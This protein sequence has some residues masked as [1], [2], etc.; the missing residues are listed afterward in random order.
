M[1][2]PSPDL[3]AAALPWLVGALA[4]GALWLWLQAEPVRHYERR[5]PGTDRVGAPPPP[6][7]A[8]NVF[9][10]GQSRT[11]PGQPADIAGSWP[12]FRGAARDG[13]AAANRPLNL[14]WGQTPPPEL[15]GVE[16]G[17]GYAAPAIEAGR[18]FLLDYDRQAQHD[19]MRCWSLEDGR[20]IW[21]YSYPVTV[22]RNHGM[23]RTVPAVA[24]DYVVGMGPK[25]HTICLKVADG[26]F[27]WGVDLVR[28]YGSVV[29]AWY[30]G[31]CPLIDR[32][33]VI[34]APGGKALLLA[35][36]LATG[37]VL[38]QTPNPR[39]WQM[40]HSSVVPMTVGSRRLFVY[41]ASGGLAGV[42]AETGA[43]LWD[44]EEWQ[45]KIAMV[46]TP[47]PLPDGR[48]FIA[49]GY[50]SG[51][52]MLQVRED[53][54]RFRSEVLYRLKPEIFGAAQQTPLLF[55]DYI[56][57]VR[58]DGALTCLDLAGKV[59]WTSGSESRYGLGP[60]LIVGETLLALDDNGMLSAV[61]A[62][63]DRFELLARKR[64]LAGHESWGPLAFVNGRLLARD[65]THLGCIDLRQAP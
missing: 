44:S 7:E 36:D 47:V 59:Q 54:G 11:G 62:S 58:P 2:K 27:V 28:E 45:V 13:I 26:S 5:V 30:A 31:Q 24:G 57:G 51:S 50:N 37:K 49:G 4:V 65:F 10:A 64:I 43:L 39:G 34:L 33:R 41:C 6:R 18:V 23:S 38:W 17:E 16:L 9:A 19:L 20:E 60:C 1:P 15:W 14:D 56:Y 29:P 22:K 61:R 25:C 12:C 42:D 55:R 35:L 32:D 8:A 63:P 40:T 53:Q 52:L 46:A 48:L 21:R 3:A